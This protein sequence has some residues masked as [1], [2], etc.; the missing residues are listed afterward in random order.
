[1]VAP[2]METASWS[3]LGF[4]DSSLKDSDFL[5]LVAVMTNFAQR[6][7]IHRRSQKRLAVSDSSRVPLLSN[8]FIF[9]GFSSQFFTTTMCVNQIELINLQTAIHSA[10]SRWWDF[11]LGFFGPRWAR[12][13]SITPLLPARW[14]ASTGS[15]GRNYRR[16]FFFHRKDGPFLG[17][18]HGKS[19]RND[20]EKLCEKPHGFSRLT[21]RMVTQRSSDGV[22]RTRICIVLQ[23]ASRMNWMHC[24]TMKQDSEWY[25]PQWPDSKQFLDLNNLSGCFAWSL[26]EGS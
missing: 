5:R 3:F 14:I 26:W 12:S 16:V 6:G 19:H 24:N 21:K 2:L 13:T 8:L 20:L 10:S 22:G 18:N 17:E 1:M 4:G 9:E 11:R 15:V 7:R 25:Y 23:E